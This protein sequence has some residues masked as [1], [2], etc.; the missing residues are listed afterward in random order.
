MKKQYKIAIMAGAFCMIVGL[1]IAGGAFAS[2]C[3][4]NDEGK[5]ISIED[6]SNVNYVDITE[7]PVGMYENVVIN[8]SSEDVRLYLTDGKT[9][10]DAHIDDNRKLTTNIGNDSLEINITDKNKIRLSLIG[11]E[12]SYINVYLSKADFKGSLN[13]KTSSGNIEIP[14]DFTFKGVILG[15]S[16]GDI[17]SECTA[18]GIVTGVASS[19]KV[20]ISNADA[21]EISVNTSSGNILLEN[22]KSSKDVTIGSSSG[23][24]IIR[25]LTAEAFSSESSSGDLK[26]SDSNISGLLERTASSGESEFKDTVS[27]SLFVKSTSGDVEFEKID[28]HNINIATSSG[29]VE[30]SFMSGKIFDVDTT[31]GDVKTPHD[32]GTDKCTVNTTSGDVEIRIHGK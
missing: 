4:G 22:C 13:V 9:R 24:Q 5:G 19:G 23:D 32:E 3:L 1:L 27:G 20:N 14:K 11:Y 29:E 26:L 31:S 2:S 10:V 6:F 25:N 17:V 30:G 12:N 15:S 21:I 7:E 18:N 28:A 8:T 16:S